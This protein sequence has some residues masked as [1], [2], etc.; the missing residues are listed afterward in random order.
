MTQVLHLQVERVQ[1]L[2]VVGLGRDRDNRGTSDSTRRATVIALGT[3]S[4]SRASV[5]R[6][7]ESRET[8]ESHR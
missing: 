5:M 3:F 1:E 2:Q 7:H 4:E 8:H 6:D